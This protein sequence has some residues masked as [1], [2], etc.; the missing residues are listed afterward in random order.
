M[1]IARNQGINRLASHFPSFSHMI[2][3]FLET[4]EIQDDEGQSSSLNPRDKHIQHIHLIRLQF[5]FEWTQ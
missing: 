1:E 3:E 2:H 4:Q 5:F